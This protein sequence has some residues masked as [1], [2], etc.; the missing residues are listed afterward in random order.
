MKTG[1]APQLRLSVHLQYY[2]PGIE[3][4]GVA[5]LSTKA[6]RAYLQYTNHK[7]VTLTTTV[8]QHATT[9]PSFRPL[10]SGN[11][12]YR[13]RRESDAYLP[14]ECRWLRDRM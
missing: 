12:L 4:R 10:S 13:K 7:G 8:T 2:R 1:Y 9:P 14:D 6:A 3:D 11:T 5:W